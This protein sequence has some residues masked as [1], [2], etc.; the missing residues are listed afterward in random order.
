MV[1][2]ERFTGMDLLC[3]THMRDNS[4]LVSQNIKYI[5][6]TLLVQVTRT[7]IKHISASIAVD[8]FLFPIP[9][10]TALFST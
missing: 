7:S 1:K 2:V 6:H 10:C 3:G 5:L 9:Y 8:S 4:C